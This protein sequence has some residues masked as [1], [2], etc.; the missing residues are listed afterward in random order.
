MSVAA[1][2]PRETSLLSGVDRK[3]LLAGLLIG[4]GGTDMR[5]TMRGNTSKQIPV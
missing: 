5:I 4:A 3:F 2:L 1:N